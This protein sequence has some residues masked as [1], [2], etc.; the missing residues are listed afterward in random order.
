MANT[1]RPV[2]MPFEDDNRGR[3]YVWSLCRYS[4]R[5]AF[6]PSKNAFVS[7]GP[8]APGVTTNSDCYLP[9]LRC[10]DGLADNL[11]G[12]APGV[13]ASAPGDGYYTI[14]LDAAT[15]ETVQA[16]TPIGRNP[17]ITE[18]TVLVA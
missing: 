11:V 7:P 4:D 17:Y 5:L 8:Y 10:P 13:P 14:V 18:I 15:G 1:N 2:C 3:S 6:S 12:V 9:L 16:A